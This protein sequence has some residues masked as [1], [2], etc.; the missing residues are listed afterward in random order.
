MEEFINA[1]V[2]NG[3]GVASFIAFIYFINTYMSKMDNTMSEISKTLTLIQ[4]N[5]MTLQSRID[6]IEEKIK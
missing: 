2:N 6:D 5:L 3:L 1:I 4:G